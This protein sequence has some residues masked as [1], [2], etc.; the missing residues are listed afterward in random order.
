MDRRYFHSNG[1]VNRNWVWGNSPSPPESVSDLKEAL[2]LDRR[3]R[4]MV[5]HG[6]TDLVTPY[7][8]TQLVLDQ[9]PSY[10]DAQRISLVVYPGGHMFYSRELS[11]KAFREDALNLT[12]RIIVESPGLSGEARPFASESRSG[13]EQGN[14]GL[15]IRLGVG[16]DALLDPFHSPARGH[17]L[18]LPR[19]G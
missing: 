13:L 17:G 5:V 18:A 10:G 3:L 6:Y 14:R 4:V 12:E 16:F 2:G 1:E 7:F 19:A 15:R 8:A 11:R 9:L